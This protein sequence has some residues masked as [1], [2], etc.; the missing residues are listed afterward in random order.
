MITFLLALCVTVAQLAPSAPEQLIVDAVNDQRAM[1]GLPA[2]E[3]IPGLQASS[4]VK[5][6]MMISHGFFSHVTPW[7]EWPNGLV[8]R[9]GV[10]LPFPDEGNRVEALYWGHPNP[11]RAVSA[12]LDSPAHRRLLLDPQAGGIGVSFR[13]LAETDRRTGRLVIH[14]VPWDGGV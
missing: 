10:P 12:V 2:L 3:V 14:V 6:R 5:N 11:L 13:R 7:G 1:V 4:H 8:R 9:A